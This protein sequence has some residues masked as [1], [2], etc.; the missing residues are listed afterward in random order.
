[1][2]YDII[3]RYVVS[4]YSML[5]CIILYYIISYYIILYHIISYYIILYQITL[6]HVIVY[7]II[8]CYVTIYH[9]IS[10][11]PSGPPRPARTPHG[12]RGP[13]SRSCGIVYVS[14]FYPDHVILTQEGEE[15]REK[16]NKRR[17]KK[18]EERRDEIGQKRAESPW[19][20]E[21]SLSN[22]NS[23]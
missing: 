15:K 6:Y 5:Y 18:R 8:V 21:A 23:N 17:E 2:L 13:R 7:Y 22:Y 10:Y 3:L 20:R 9:I 19:R 11:R 1:M 16:I 4:Y 14:I 12:A